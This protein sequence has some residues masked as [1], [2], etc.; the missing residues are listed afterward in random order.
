MNWIQTYSG[1]PFDLTDP[2][3]AAVN[4]TDIAHA[5]GYLCRFTGHTIHPFSVAMHSLMVADLVPVEHRL[6]ALLHDAHEAYVGDVSTPLKWEV[7]AFRE[8]SDRVWHAVADAFNVPRELHPTVKA[9]DRVM[10]MTERRDLLTACPEPWAAEFE[11][12][13]PRPEKIGLPD[14]EGFGRVDAW[15]FERAVKQELLRQRATAA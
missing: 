5:L 11:A 10:L 3:P 7:P 15:R 12:V 6:Q 9:A 4:L 1:V 14:C 2:N 13:E 8:V